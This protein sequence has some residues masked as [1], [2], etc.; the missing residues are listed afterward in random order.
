MGSTPVTGM[1]VISLEGRKLCLGDI[2]AHPGDYGAIL[3]RARIEHSARCLCRTPALPLVVRRA[4]SGRH[5]LACWPLQGPEHDPSCV[6]FGL[7]PEL[8]GRSGYTHAAI[9]EDKTGVSIRLAVPLTTTNTATA[10]NEDR[11]AA[12]GSGTRRR[13]VGLLGTLHYFWESARL[14]HWVPGTKRDWTKAA[15]A[16]HNQLGHCTISRQAAADAVYVIAPYRGADNSDWFDRFLDRRASRQGRGLVVGELLE[17]REARHGVS[18]HLAHQPRRWIFAAQALDERIRRSYRNA[19]SVAAGPT[20]R[21]VGLFYIERSPKGYAIALDAAVMLTNRDYIPVESSWELRM[22]DALQRAG[23][24]YIKPLVYDGREKVLPDF[25]LTDRPRSYVEVWGMPGR[26]EYE[27]RKA[28][29]LAH[30]QR[31]A[32]QLIEWTVTEPLP[33]LEILK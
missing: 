1:G 31:A 25:V 17:T 6:F 5:H 15:T 30:Y 19:F 29:K 14:T 22:A 4:Q 10:P 13:S 18:Y 3:A 21:R 20:A 32:L 7:E 8:S 11:G 28:K 33:V 12:G 9:R 26:E 23:R 2:R 16:V 24:S 27:Q